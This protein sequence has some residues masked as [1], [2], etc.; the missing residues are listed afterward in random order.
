M[1][2]EAAE[3]AEKAHKGAV[4]KGSDIPYITHPLETAVLTSMMSDDEELIAAA[5]LHDTLEDAGVSYEELRR[6]FGRHVADLVAEETEDKS[7]TWIERKSRTIEHLRSAGREI[8]ILTLADKLSNIRSTARD[9]LL[10]GERVWER[11]NV[12]EK[13]KHAWYY[14]SMVYLLKD[15]ADYPEYQEYVKLCSAVF[16]SEPKEETPCGPMLIIRQAE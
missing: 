9:Y 5:L 16:G 12:K 2:R 4:R 3:F 15:L 11:F 1:I 10:V 7:K 13:D 8:K 6:H 14:Q